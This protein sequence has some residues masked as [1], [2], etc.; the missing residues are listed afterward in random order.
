[1]PSWTGWRLCREIRLP[2]RSSQSVWQPELQNDEHRVCACSPFATAHHHHNT[3]SSTS[4]QSFHKS[5]ADLA[6]S[7]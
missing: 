2:A 7:C 6:R 5:M 4:L 1:M 3:C